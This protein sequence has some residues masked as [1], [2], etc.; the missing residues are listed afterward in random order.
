MEPRVPDNI[1]IYA[2]GDIHGKLDL[3]EALQEKIV[4]DANDAGSTQ[5]V[6]IFLGDYVD[7]GPNSKGVVDWLLEPP[8]IGWRRIC[9]KGNHEA[10]VLNFF[11]T[12][13]IIR[14][15][16]RYGGLE[17][18]QSYGVNLISLQGE[19]APDILMK[20]Y[21]KKFP[22]T[23]FEFFSNLPLFVEFGDYFFVHAGVRPGVALNEQKEE[24]LTWIR[25]EFLLSEMDFGKVI[26]HGHTPRQQPE[27]LA[28]RINIDT[29]AYDTGRL[30]CLVLEN[31]WQRI[32]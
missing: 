8:P 23:H 13:E 24:D 17:N 27:I 29:R 28:N 4:A 12:P 10:H 20:D 15:W 2:I 21:S 25:D 11:K 18:L 26:V 32:L 22:Q 5:I 9:L 3:L 19:D 14:N 6:Q 31:G 30:T 16:Q 1:R 7:R